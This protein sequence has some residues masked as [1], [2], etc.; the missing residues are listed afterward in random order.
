MEDAGRRAVAVPGD[1]AGEADCGELIDRAVAE[2]GGIDILVNNAAYQ[3][4]QDKA[5]RASPPSSS[6]G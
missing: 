4:S 3:M 2:F 1:I 6:T 5:S